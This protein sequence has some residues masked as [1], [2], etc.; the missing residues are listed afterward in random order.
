MT[1]N[2]SV[3]IYPY[4]TQPSELGEAF[5]CRIEEAVEEYLDEKFEENDMGIRYEIENLFLQY[6]LV[7][8]E[9]LHMYDR[10][11]DIKV[12]IKMFKD[13]KRAYAEFLAENPGYEGVFYGTKKPKSPVTPPSTP[14]KDVCSTETSSVN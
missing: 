8:L 4:E 2:S 10:A 1:D 6:P 9:F 5:C 12:P 13:S 11:E 14:K 7:A 3:E